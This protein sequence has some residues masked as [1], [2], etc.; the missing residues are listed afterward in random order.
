M[1]IDSK[2]PSVMTF[3]EGVASIDLLIWICGIPRIPEFDIKGLGFSWGWRSGGTAPNRADQRVTYF[4]KKF[5]LK[6]VMNTY[7]VL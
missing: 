2:L 4:E 5:Q 1:I 7:S 3:R 6:H